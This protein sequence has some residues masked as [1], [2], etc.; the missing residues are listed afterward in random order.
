MRRPP[1]R[2]RDQVVKCQFGATQVHRSGGDLSTPYGCDLD[3]D[4]VRRNKP[5]P[6]EPCT[7][8]ITIGAVVAECW[9]NNARVDNYQ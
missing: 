9:R 6:V 3:I 4:E 1:H 8:V 7:S 2:H 5:L